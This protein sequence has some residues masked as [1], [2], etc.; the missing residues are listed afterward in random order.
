MS[1]SSLLYATVALLAVP[2]VARASNVVGQIKF[3]LEL[4]VAAGR[5]MSIR[6]PEM[7]EGEAHA[8]VKWNR[9]AD[10]VKVK[11]KLEGVPYQPS[12]CF[13]VDPST[14]Y[15]EYPFCVEDGAWQMWFV[16]RMFT[17]STT[18]YYDSVSGDLIANEFDLLSGPPPGSIPVVLP[19]AQMMCSGLFQPNPNSLEVH[20]E[21]DYGYNHMVD[22]IGTPGTLVGLLP[23][24]LFDPS[25]VWV[26]YTHE[27]LPDSEAQDFDTTLAELEA[28][29][30]GFA[31]STSV[32]PLIKPPAL[33]THD[34]LMIGWT[35]SYPDFFLEPAAPE[36]FEDPDCGTEQIFVPFI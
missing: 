12:Y 26:Y 10:H 7:C 2:G 5:E 19:A 25:S 33:L 16:S 17:R 34:Q 8:K 35:N 6:E 28:G 4:G 24:N 23:Y 32:E 27:I 30:G 29:I 18:W 3:D 31:V 11:L 14:D 1:K 9:N 15:N 36:A 22:F 13:E 21:F 20:Y